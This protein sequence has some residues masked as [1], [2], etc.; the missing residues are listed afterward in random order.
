MLGIAGSKAIE[1]VLERLERVP[2]N[3]PH[4]EILGLLSK[5][6]ELGWDGQWL[7]WDDLGD[8]DPGWGDV[9]D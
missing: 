6:V 8:D 1:R 2:S 5:D 3:E 4:D 7:N 9:G